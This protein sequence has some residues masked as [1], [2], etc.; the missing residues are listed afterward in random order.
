MNYIYNTFLAGWCADAVGARLEFQRTNFTDTQVEDAFFM[1]G[2]K[3]SGVYPGQITDDSE[4]EIAL[5]SA[6]IECKDEPYFPIE[7][8]AKKYIE[9]YKTNP[10]D[11]GQTIATALYS[12]NDASDMLTNSH[13]FNA[14]SESNGSLMRCIPLAIFGIT[15]T[16]E[17]IMNIAIAESQLTHSNEIVGIITGIYC[18]IITHILRCKIN[19]QNINIKELFNI[20]KPYIESN[21]KI[22][23]WYNIANTMNMNNIGDYDSITHEG[24]VKH[25][26]IFYIYFLKNIEFY[27]YVS[28]I[29]KVIKCGGDT[30]TNAKIVGNLFGAYYD[31]CVPEHLSDIVLGFDCTALQD[32]FYKRPYSCS[33]KYGVELIKLNF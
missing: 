9:W 19:N 16:N 13:N 8:I 25:A 29:T 30:D 14:N 33:V 6:L 23:D 26:F 7:T 5:L 10:F 2:E 28:A 31:N 24:H 17:I 32:N 1:K 4:M 22:N 15:R 18:I 27:N 3:S 21:E 11:I 12:A 20:I